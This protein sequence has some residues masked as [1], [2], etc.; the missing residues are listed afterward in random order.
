MALILRTLRT[1]FMRTSCSRLCRL[2]KQGYEEGY[3]HGLKEGVMEEY[4]AGQTNGWEVAAEVSHTKME[5]LKCF[6]YTS[7]SVYPC[8]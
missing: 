5:T 6:S 1:L 3:Q 7:V 8:T 2:R 4:I